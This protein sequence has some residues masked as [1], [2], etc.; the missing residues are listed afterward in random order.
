MAKMK[1]ITIDDDEP[2]YEKSDEYGKTRLHAWVLI[3]KGLRE[4]PETIF[5]EP[6]TGR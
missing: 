2:D 6:T 4:M 1:E 5:I 3:R